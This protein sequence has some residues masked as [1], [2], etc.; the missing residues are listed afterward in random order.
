MTPQAGNQIIHFTR[1]ALM[2]PA[3]SY[4]IDHGVPVTKYMLQAGLSPNALDNQAALI[5]TNLAYRFVNA[6][7]RAHGIEDIG[8]LVGQ[9][10]SVQAMGEFG[11]LLMSAESIHD[12]LIKGC[13]LISSTTN[14]DYYWLVDEADEMRFCQS[15]SGL[16]EHDKVQNYLFIAL[17]TINTIRQAL[18]ECWCPPEITIPAMTPVTGVKLAA[19]LPG[20]RIIREGSHASFLI[21]YTLLEQPMVPEGNRASTRQSV[22]PVPSLPNDFYASITQVIESLIIAGYPNVRIAAEAAGVSSRTLQRRLAACGTSYSEMVAQVRISLAMRWI[23]NGERSLVDIAHALGYTDPA[24]FSR[25]FR[26]IN[27]LSPRAYRD[28]IHAS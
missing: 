24:N 12:Y 6:A 8:L 4:L 19:V 22:F 18:S 15:I 10:T 17:V 3:V 25:A 5:P 9:A 14:S 11:R 2:Q 20:T 23:R 16:D 1:V 13:Q 28:S 27:G 26:R 21:P 7:C